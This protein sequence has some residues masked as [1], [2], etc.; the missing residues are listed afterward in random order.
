[1]ANIR[2]CWS[3]R[4][5]AAGTDLTASSEL[6]A[7]PVSLT[8]SDDRSN[9][10]QSATGTG[11]Q[12]IDIDL[13]AV[14][15]VEAV[16]L[17]NAKV[18]G[19]GVI[20]LYQRGDGGAPGAAVLVATL[21]APDTQTRAMAAFFASQSHRHWQLK[22]T[23]PSAA[24][25][26]AQLGYA[27]LGEYDEPTVNVMVPLPGG[28]VDPSVRANS[29]DGQAAFALRTK[30]QQGAFVFDAVPQAQL[31][32]LQTMFDG[33]GTAVPLFIVLD[34]AISWMCWFARIGSLTW[35]VEPNGAI[36]RYSP[37]FP[38]EEVR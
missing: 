1:M 2:F 22:W 11:V 7:M 18:I 6:T 29:V 26:Y 35:D 8:K 14:V 5:T 19:V 17:A 3:N 21:A 12:T 20:E 32:Q 37:K 10:W 38:W 28:R 23:N 16:A 36:G 13:G 4:Y 27:F 33:I 34:T 9:V 25:D 31:E 24:S 30:F 15:A